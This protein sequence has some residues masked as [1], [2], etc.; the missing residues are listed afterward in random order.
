MRWTAG[1]LALLLCSCGYHTAGHADLMPK[2]IQSVCIP[3]FRNAT[4]RYKLSDHLPEA[5]SREFIA[6]TRYH[7]S[8]DLDS[9]DAILRG[10]VVNYL[11]NQTTVDPVTGRATAADI[12]VFLSITFTERATGQVLYSN[13]SFTMNERYEISTDPI[14]YFEESDAGLNRVATSVA[15]QVVSA[16]LN[17]F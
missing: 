5:I 2:T 15:R 14:A 7:I 12:H 3:A 17:K 13:P 6:R 9:C 4:S 1:A 11:A 16:I 8:S 10:Q